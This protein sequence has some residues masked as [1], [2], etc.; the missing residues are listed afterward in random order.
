MMLNRDISILDYMN[1]KMGIVSKS[2]FN[3]NGYLH[4]F[5]YSSLEYL[6]YPLQ[7]EGDNNVDTSCNIRLGPKVKFSYKRFN[8][9]RVTNNGLGVSHGGIG[10]IYSIGGVDRVVAYPIGTEDYYVMSGRFYRSEADMSVMEVLAKDYIKGNSID[11]GMLDRVVEDYYKWSRL[12]QFYYGVV[13][14]TVLKEVVRS[15]KLSTPN[16]IFLKSTPI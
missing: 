7:L 1:Q 15:G 11:R 9:L 2:Q 3:T 10:D 8:E 13:I 14:L 4:G 12:E 16:P 5:K 6:V